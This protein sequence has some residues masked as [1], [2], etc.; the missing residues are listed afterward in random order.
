MQ[1]LGHDVEI[2]QEPPTRRH[3]CANSR[4]LRLKIAYCKY[5]DTLS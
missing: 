5:S 4:A 1:I 3:A 2:T